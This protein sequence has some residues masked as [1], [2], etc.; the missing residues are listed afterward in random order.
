MVI[1]LRGG[2]AKQKTTLL[3]V[4]KSPHNTNTPKCKLKI[5]DTLYIKEIYKGKA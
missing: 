1:P 2:C 5:K 3:K 4:K